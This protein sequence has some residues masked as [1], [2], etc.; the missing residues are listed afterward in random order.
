MKLRPQDWKSGE[1]AWLIDMVMPFGGRDEALKEVKAQVF[2]DRLL[3]TVS[4]SKLG[5]TSTVSY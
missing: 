3:T 5:E 2:P 4:L 1:K